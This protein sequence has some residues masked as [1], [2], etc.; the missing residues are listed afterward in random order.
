ME[1]AMVPTRKKGGGERG[2]ERARDRRSERCEEDVQ[3]RWPTR[4]PILHVERLAGSMLK[5]PLG[6]VQD[7][8]DPVV[9]GT[10]AIGEK[11]DA[12]G[13]ALDPAIEASLQ[14]LLDSIQLNVVSSRAK[15][16]AEEPRLQPVPSGWGPKVR[17]G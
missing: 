16:P 13:T 6:T 17:G 11:R 3:E 1:S 15:L 14:G 12:D 4:C 8:A 2:Y 10:A 9:G 5:G 7:T